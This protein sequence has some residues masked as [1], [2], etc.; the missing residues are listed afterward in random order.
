MF[1]DY[2]VDLRHISSSDGLALKWFMWF[3]DTFTVS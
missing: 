3:V 2:D 1:N